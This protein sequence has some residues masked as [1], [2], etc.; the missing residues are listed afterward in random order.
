MKK[1]ETDMVAYICNLSTE[2]S[3]AEGFELEAYKH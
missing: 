1:A 2:E 3:E